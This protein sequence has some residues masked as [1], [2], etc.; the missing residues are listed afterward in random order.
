MQSILHGFH[1]DAAVLVCNNPVK[2]CRRQLRTEG[3]PCQIHFLKGFLCL[4]YGCAPGQN[5]RNKLILRHIFLIRNFLCID[6]ISHKVQ[7]CHAKALF[8]GR[9]IIKRITARH[10][11]HTDH[12]IMVLHDPCIVKRNGVIPRHHRNLFPVGKLIIQR[13]SH[14]EIFCPIGCC[15][16]HI[17]PPTDPAD[18]YP[19][20]SDPAS[21]S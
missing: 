4:G 21:P 18:T 17:N 9:I 19:H 14:I 16:T 12:G 13:P 15:C 7:S 20:L 2:L 3:R 10:M 1:H 5:P 11:R 6:G 8:I